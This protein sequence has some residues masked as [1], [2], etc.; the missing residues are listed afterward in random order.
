MKSGKRPPPRSEANVTENNEVN[1]IDLIPRQGEVP[2]SFPTVSFASEPEV[3]EIHVAEKTLSEAL[4]SSTS[5]T[6]QLDF[7]K[8][9]VAAMDSACNRTCAG[10]TWIS[11]MLDALQPLNMC[12]I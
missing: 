5:T 8:Y 9:Y 2:Y 10:S 1:V 3:H 11:T 7:D 4:I 12:K 6:A